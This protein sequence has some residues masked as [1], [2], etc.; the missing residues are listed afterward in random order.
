VSPDAT[1]V[2]LGEVARGLSRVETEM[3]AGFK[4]LREELKTLSF[5]DSAVYSADKVAYHDRVAR[6]EADL[7]DERTLR[8]EAD[9][10]AQQRAWQ[11]RWSI[12]LAVI[13]MPISI[14]GAVV[15]A[16]VVAALK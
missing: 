11:S 5:V 1:E 16:L 6:L 10:V 13:G 4:A 8:R 2:T 14:L 7:E 3:H 15:A 9:A 12:I